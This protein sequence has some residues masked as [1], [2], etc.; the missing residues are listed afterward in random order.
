TASHAPA[1]EWIITIWIPTDISDSITMDMIKTALK[2]H[3]GEEPVRVLMYLPSG[4][5]VR[6]DMM[7]DP[8]D[9]LKNQLIG[10]LGFENVKF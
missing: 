3:A 8:T 2:R 1:P 7:L 9:S 4:K 5:A 6:S 10:L